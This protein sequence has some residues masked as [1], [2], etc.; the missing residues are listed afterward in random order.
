MTQVVYVDVLL[1]INFVVNYFLLLGTFHL[2]R[3]PVVRLRLFWGALLG[4]GFSLPPEEGLQKRGT[5]K[6][7]PPLKKIT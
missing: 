3:Q 4:A 6:M 2:A 7:V 1:A 5:N